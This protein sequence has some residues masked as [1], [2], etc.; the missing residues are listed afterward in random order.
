MAEDPEAKN[1]IDVKNPHMSKLGNRPLNAS[2]A[3][4]MAE[5]GFVTFRSTLTSVA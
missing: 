1:K 4:K 2:H 3:K 5:T